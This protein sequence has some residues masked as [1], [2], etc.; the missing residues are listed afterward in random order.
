METEKAFYDMADVADVAQPGSPESPKY[1]E[2]ESSSHPDR[3]ISQ[4]TNKEDFDKY[5]RNHRVEIDLIV[6][7]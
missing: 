2:G 6:S 1:I 3:P 5:V 4:V 7:N